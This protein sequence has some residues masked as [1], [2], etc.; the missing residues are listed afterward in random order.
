MVPR[1]FYITVQIMLLQTFCI[2]SASIC[3]IILFSAKLEH[4][5]RIWYT[6]HL[7]SFKY[8]WRGRRCIIYLGLESCSSLLGI[9]FLQSM[10]HFNTEAI[11]STG[12]PTQRQLGFKSQHNQDFFS[13]WRYAQWDYVTVFFSSKGSASDPC[14]L[15]RAPPKNKSLNQNPNQDTGINP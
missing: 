9:L 7:L 5:E 8:Y 14:L 15:D 2:V 1:Y 10:Y 11:I 12:L 6:I 13:L 3:H 4:L